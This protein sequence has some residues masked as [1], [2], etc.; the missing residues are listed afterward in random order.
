M[1]FILSVRTKNGETWYRCYS[2]IM[3]KDWNDA[4]VFTNIGRAS[5]V[6]RKEFRLH[7]DGIRSY[8][9]QQADDFRNVYSINTKEKEDN[10]GFKRI[11]MVWGFKRK[12]K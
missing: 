11:R 9:I 3:S 7:R 1:S 5:A 6:A 2:G 12:N 10:K 8:C 4:H